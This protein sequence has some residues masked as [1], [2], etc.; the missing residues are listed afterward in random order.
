[1]RRYFQIFV[2]ICIILLLEISGILLA[3]EFEEDI[4]LYE[5][6]NIV[7]FSFEFNPMYASDLIKLN[8]EIETITKNNTID[9]S[10]YVNVFGGIGENF[11]ISPNGIYEITTKQDSILKLK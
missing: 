8:P 10:G 3:E 5:G 4:K 2:L 7:N 11:I 6:K 9:G 1:M